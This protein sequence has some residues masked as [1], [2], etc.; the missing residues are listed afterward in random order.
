[1]RNLFLWR[2]YVGRHCDAILYFQCDIAPPRHHASTSTTQDI[3]SNDFPQSTAKR[4]LLGA[5]PTRSP[6][7]DK[8]KEM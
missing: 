1:M 5:R 6:Q 2:P 3:K 7:F 8:S 4:I